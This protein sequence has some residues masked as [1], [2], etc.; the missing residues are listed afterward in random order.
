[1]AILMWLVDDKKVRRGW[2]GKLN[3]I[4]QV[5]N[6]LKPQ[7]TKGELKE[8]EMVVRQYYR[9]YNDGDYPRCVMRCNE[10]SYSSVARI[11]RALESV[12]TD[13]LLKLVRKYR[14]EF[15]K[16]RHDVVNREKAS[17]LKIAVRALEEDFSMGTVDYWIE[18][19]NVDVLKD[20]ESVELLKEVRGLHDGFCALMVPLGLRYIP[21]ACAENLDAEK[22]AF[23]LEMYKRLVAKSKLLAAKLRFD[24][25]KFENEK[26]VIGQA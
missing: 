18:K 3:N 24:L 25:T 10:T 21:R 19:S 2:H 4:N 6:E 12:L 22:H 5:L 13:V 15:N 20:K 7:F 16:I 9:Y 17:C 26:G 8:Y 14:A 1:M 11:E 23:E